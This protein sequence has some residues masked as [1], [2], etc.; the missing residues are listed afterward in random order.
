MKS[1]VIKFVGRTK[2][3]VKDLLVDIT[4]DDFEFDINHWE[5][6]GDDIDGSDNDFNVMDDISSNMI[7]RKVFTEDNYVCPEFMELLIRNKGT[8]RTAVKTYKD[9][10]DSDYVISIINYDYRNIEIISK[11][12]RIINKIKDNFSSINVSD[13]KIIEVNDI[14]FDV[15]LKAWR[16]GVGIEGQ[17]KL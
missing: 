11:D 16:K 9:F 8:K 14:S 2:N 1:L 12:D 10:I 3:I 7:L 15:E 5:S 13:K 17:I 6:Y 4:F